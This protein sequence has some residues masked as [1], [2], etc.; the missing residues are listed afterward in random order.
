MNFIEEGKDPRV[1]HRKEMMQ[2]N[3]Q[4]ALIPIVQDIDLDPNN[5]KTIIPNGTTSRS[6][7]GAEVYSK[8][9]KS[10]LLRQLTS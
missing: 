9:T 7:G 5:K 2:S 4:E 3:P 10:S 8:L 1:V 6:L